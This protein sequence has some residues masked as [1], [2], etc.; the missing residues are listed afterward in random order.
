MDLHDIEY[1]VT[2]I[3]EKSFSRAAAKLYLTQ[4]TLSN[5]MARLE[6]KTGVELIIRGSHSI[7]PTKFGRLYY[8]TGKAILEKRDQLYQDLR[9]MKNAETDMITFGSNSERTVR[10]ISRILPLFQLEYPDT[11][12]ILRE[13]VEPELIKDVQNNELDFCIVATQNDYLDIDRM[14]I[15]NDELYL[16][17]TKKH[18]L[19][20][21]AATFGA[22]APPRF[23]IE[24]FRDD[25]F[26]LLKKK[27]VL[28]EITNEYF[29]KAGFVPD[30]IMETQNIRTSL[31][32][33]SGGIGTVTFCPRGYDASFQELR[34]VALQ[35]APFYSVSICCRSGE[36]R[37][38]SMNR[39][40]KLIRECREEY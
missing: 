3:E 7:V 31:L 24:E 20:E 10:Y 2:L 35:A 23:S 4:P 1:F 21:Q 39:F 8:E 12:I 30:I 16:A 6:K 22:Q 5:F 38:A 9:D 33:L 28:R 18:R 13:N 25:S 34:Y 37:N 29:R 36:S 19:Y 11:E 15:S 26:I 27:S 32:M 17:L 14:P 40:L